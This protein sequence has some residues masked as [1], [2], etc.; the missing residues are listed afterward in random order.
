[1]NDS[2]RATLDRDGLLDTFVAELTRAAYDVALRHRAA[3]TWLDLQLD[4]WR[5]LAHT[6]KQWGRKPPPGAECRS[7][8][9][10]DPM[11]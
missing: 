10:I 5:A 11:R 3:G 7:P 8:R 6:V 2:T 1:M 4:L 9:E